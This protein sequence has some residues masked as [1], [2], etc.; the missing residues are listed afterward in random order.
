MKPNRPP[1][2]R[3]TPPEKPQA[4]GFLEW[5]L[6]PSLRKDTDSVERAFRTKAFAW[7]AY[8][9]LFIGAVIMGTSGLIAGIVAMLLITGVVGGGALLLGNLIGGSVRGATNPKRAG[10]RP[11]HSRAEALLVRGEH[12]EA[13]DLLEV[14]LVENPDDA[15]A[16]LR[17]ARI[18]RDARQDSD[19]ALRWF[20]KGRASGCFTNPQMRVSM[21]EIMDLARG[22]LDLAAIA[23]DLAMHRDHFPGTDEGEWAERELAE[24]KRGM[25]R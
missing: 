21:R 2:N 25:E 22:T 14:S 9:G 17:I 13:L 6:R 5:L 20:R 10:K 18:H 1:A 24:V 15:E 16:Y 7:G 11:S 8:P 23:P 4:R 19:Q 12:Q 3:Q